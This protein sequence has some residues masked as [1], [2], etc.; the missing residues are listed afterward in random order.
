[1]LSGKPI[2]DFEADDDLFLR[3]K[4]DKLVKTLFSRK[5]AE[6]AK[7]ISFNINKLNLRP[8]PFDFAQGREARRQVLSNGGFARDF[9]F[10][11]AIKIPLCKIMI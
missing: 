2:E 7:K 5:D 11:E 1:M 4:I 10:L 9:H 3:L 6:N 8:L